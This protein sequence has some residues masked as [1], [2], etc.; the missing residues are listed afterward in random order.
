MHTNVGDGHE[1]EEE[2]EKK[3]VG[4]HTA[5]TCAHVYVPT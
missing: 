3:Y 2:E 4:K 1:E 5:C